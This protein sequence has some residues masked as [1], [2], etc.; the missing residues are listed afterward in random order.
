VRRGRV[1]AT[2]PSEQSFDLATE[3][4]QAYEGSWLACRLIAGHSG[5]AGLVRFYRM[6]GGSDDALRALATALRAV[7]HES[8]AEFTAQWRAYLKAQL[9]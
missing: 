3:S 5:R 1:P 4:A 8:T 9:G 7:M 6:V 2:L